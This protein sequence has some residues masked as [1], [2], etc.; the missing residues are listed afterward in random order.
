MDMQSALNRVVLQEIAKSAAFRRSVC[1]K[2][3]LSGSGSGGSGSGGSG[4]GGGGVGSIFGATV[5]LGY[6][7]RLCLDAVNKRIVFEGLRGAM[8]SQQIFPGFFY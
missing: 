4:G 2:V 1:L 6:Y 3:E 7:C 8:A 5:P